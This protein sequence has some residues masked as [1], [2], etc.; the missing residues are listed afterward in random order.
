MKFFFLLASL[1]IAS[2]LLLRAQWQLS[3]IIGQN[4]HA[5][6]SVGATAYAGSDSG[7]YRSTNDGVTWER[8]SSGL[9][10]S[11]FFTKTFVLTG[12]SLFAGTNGAAGLYVTTNDGGTW[13]VANS[14]LTGTQ[15]HALALQGSVLF[16]ATNGNGIFRSTNNGAGWVESNSGITNLFA[17]SLLVI[18]NRILAGTDGGAFVSTDTGGSWSLLPGSPTDIRSLASNGSILVAGTNTGGVFR[19]TNDGVTWAA[20]NAGLTSL[21]VRVIIARGGNFFTGAKAGGVAL[22]TDNGSNWLPINDGLDSLSILALET[23]TTTLFAGADLGGVW[24]RPLSQVVAV[25][26]ETPLLPAGIRLEQNYPNPFNPS[27]VI[28]YSIPTTSQVLMKVYDVLGRDVATLVDDM[29]SPGEYS[30][31]WNAASVAS[32]TYLCR[33]TNENRIEVREMMIVK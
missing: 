27:T 4:V 2:Q 8:R 25:A 11:P 3:G 28:R 26:H 5:L 29:R 32:G 19:S 30:V 16:A 1:I 13:T 33:L 12:S 9:P 21:Y 15:V 6:L 20:A 24:T 31:S 23:S 14:G 17:H 18:G 10:V 22:S 7:V